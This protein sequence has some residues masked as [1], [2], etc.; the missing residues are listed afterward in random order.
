MEQ[1]EIN[2]YICIYLPLPQT[3]IERRKVATKERKK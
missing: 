3:F 2:I 1:G